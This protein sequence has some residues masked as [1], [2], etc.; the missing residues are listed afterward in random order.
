MSYSYTQ[1]VVVSSANN[2]DATAITVSFDADTLR[3]P[4]KIR[5]VQNFLFP[6]SFH[7][8]DLFAPGDYTTING[9]DTVAREFVV[10]YDTGT[11]KLSRCRFAKFFLSGGT[12][13]LVAIDV[14][15]IAARD[16][17]A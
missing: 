1:T 3:L 2:N 10:G 4:Y 13:G 7:L 11:S 12:F 6:V 5:I 9:S 15:D 14:I 17:S 16:Q 8:D